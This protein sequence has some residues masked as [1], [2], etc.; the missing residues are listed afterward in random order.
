[1]SCLNLCVTRLLLIISKG[2]KAQCA[3][4]VGHRP[5]VHV[6]DLAGAG[7]VVLSAL[8]NVVEVDRSER[9]GA[10]LFVAERRRGTARLFARVQKLEVVAHLLVVLGHNVHELLGL[11]QRHL[12][13]DLGTTCEFTRIINSKK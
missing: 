1:V 4:G 12:R 2:Y 3:S 10:A 6:R 5:A 11:W 9:V 13:L 7:V 8:A